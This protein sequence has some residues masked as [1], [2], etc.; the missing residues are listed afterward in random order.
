[1]WHSYILKDCN[2]LHHTPLTIQMFYFLHCP[3]YI[4]LFIV[5]FFPILKKSILL[6]QPF[7]FLLSVW[8]RKF[9]SFYKDKLCFTRSNILQC[10][11]NTI[12]QPE[13]FSPSLNPSLKH[14]SINFRKNIQACRIINPCYLLRHSG[15]CIFSHYNPGYYFSHW[16]SH[17]I[18]AVLFLDIH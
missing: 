1:M 3:R 9:P 8:S 16:Q 11:I 18:E 14:N 2:C 4:Q 10:L 5:L 15:Y 13:K 12:I 6:Q 7:T 17:N